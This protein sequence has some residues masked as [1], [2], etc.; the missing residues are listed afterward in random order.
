MAPLPA[1]R[2][3]HREEDILVDYSAASITF[4]AGHRNGLS[5]TEN[6]VALFQMREYRQTALA[7]SCRGNEHIINPKMPYRSQHSEV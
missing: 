4:G 6:S 7:I 3:W 5:T 1:N 2:S